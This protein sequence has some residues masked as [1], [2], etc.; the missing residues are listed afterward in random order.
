MLP[1]VSC[2]LALSSVEG[3][4]TAHATSA[5]AKFLDFLNLLFYY[6]KADINK[7]SF[8]LYWLILD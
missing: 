8:E 5:C 6:V 3:L 1:A 4:S 2:K 7:P